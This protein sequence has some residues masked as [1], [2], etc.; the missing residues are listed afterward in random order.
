[1]I[2]CCSLVLPLLVALAG[3][4]SAQPLY[5]GQ[6]EVDTA[7]RGALEAVVRHCANLAS[8]P[9][10]TEASSDASSERP[11]LDQYSKPVAVD[12]LV[13]L[14]DDAEAA[15]EGTGT[16]MPANGAEDEGSQDTLPSLSDITVEMCKEAG[17]IY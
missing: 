7:D 14:G 11:Y 5:L 8:Q 3:P 12:T 1:M 2:R 13:S 10:G 15:G 6:Q 4:L 9:T 17:V 16:G